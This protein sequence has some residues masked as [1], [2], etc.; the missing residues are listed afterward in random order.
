MKIL[1]MFCFLMIIINFIFINLVFVSA[2]QLSISPPE[3][4]ING[5][6]GKE[7]C[8][9]LRIGFDSAGNLIGDITWSLNSSRERKDYILKSDDLNLL[10]NYPKNVYFKDRDKKII[11]I[12]FDGEKQGNYNGLL[13]YK[14][15]RGYA[16]IGIWIHLILENNKNTA[17]MMILYSSQTIL[18]LM[19][20]FLLMIKK[21]N[22]TYSSR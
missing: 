2:A 16:G 11:N 18:L 3:L 5:T 19:L 17:K 4:F 12:C 6:I 14:T 7:N 9:E 15:D 13:I 1:R 21:N 20:L 22:G 8:H 10:E